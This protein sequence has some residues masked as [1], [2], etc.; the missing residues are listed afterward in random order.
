MPRATSA[1]PVIGTRSLREARHQ[2]PGERGHDH[3]R[4][5]RRE[6]DQSGLEGVE[7]L[8][9]LEVQAEVDQ[10][11]EVRAGD[12]VDRRGRAGERAVA[13]EPEISTTPF[14]AAAF[15]EDEDH[16]SGDPSVPAAAIS[17]C[18]HPVSPPRSVA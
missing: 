16:E 1:R 11:P 4:R 18:P 6:V 13:E 2:T 8:G 7:P 5:D 15:E 9:A 3:V 12:D 17:P 10:H 14:G